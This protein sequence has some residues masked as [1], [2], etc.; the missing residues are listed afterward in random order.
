MLLPVGKLPADILDKMLKTYISL[1]ERVK[2]GPSIGE[3]AAAVD[4]GD[5]YLLEVLEL[6][7]FGRDEITKIFD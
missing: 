1:D 6:P 3:D 7:V 4:M 5:R 2:V